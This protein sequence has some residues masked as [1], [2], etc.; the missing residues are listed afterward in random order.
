MK[1]TII[2]DCLRIAEQKNNTEDHPRWGF[3]MHYSFIVQ[4]NKLIEWGVNRMGDPFIKGYHKDAYIHSETDA[5]RKAKGLLDPKKPFEVLNIRLN[6]LNE[7]RN[8]KPCPCCYA[9]IKSMGARHIYFS[10]DV[11]FVKTV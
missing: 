11:G 5:Y 6:K 8:S 2:R 7:L 9:F 3:F 10:T 4:D 1:N